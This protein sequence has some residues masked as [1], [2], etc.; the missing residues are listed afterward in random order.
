MNA[1]APDRLSD[2]DGN[3]GK[4]NGGEESSAC[5]IVARPIAITYFE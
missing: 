1:S 3:G 2:R 4:R 5:N